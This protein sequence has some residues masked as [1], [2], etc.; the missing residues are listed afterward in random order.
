MFSA[1]WLK[2]WRLVKLFHNKKMKRL[3]IYTKD[4]IKY[5]GSVM[6]LVIIL[7]FIWMFTDPFHWER[8][9]L[10]TNDFGDVIESVGYCTCNNFGASAGPLATVL[11]LCTVSFID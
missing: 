5:Q 1:C 10:R 7:N 3:R 6:L 9:T 2:T 4:L 8:E 11:G